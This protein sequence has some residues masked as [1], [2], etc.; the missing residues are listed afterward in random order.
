MGC[1]P[2]KS[3]LAV[4]QDVTGMS[5]QDAK[6][7]FSGFKKQ[8]GSSKIKLDKF[9]MFVSELNTNKGKQNSEFANFFR[10]YKHFHLLTFD[11]IN[12]KENI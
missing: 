10:R 3:D 9:T 5:K 7:S 11:V 6:D 8:T 2:S 4:V 12:F 1:G